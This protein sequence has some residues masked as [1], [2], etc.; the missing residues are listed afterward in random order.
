MK[1]PLKNKQPTAFTLIELLVVLAIIALLVAMIIPALKSAKENA[2]RVICASNL[3]QFG[4]IELNFAEDNN[5]EFIGR[6]KW[7]W[8]SYNMPDVSGGPWNNKFDVRPDLLEYGQTGRLFYCPS[9]TWHGPARIAMFE[10]LET[11]YGQL[12]IDYFLYVGSGW[13]VSWK[14]GR[15][16]YRIE[17][18][19]QVQAGGDQVMSSD[20]A[21][22]HVTMPANPNYAPYYTE[23]RPVRGN[24]TLAIG[25]DYPIQGGNRLY[26][27]GHVNWQHRDAIELA[28][29]QD[30]NRAM[31]FW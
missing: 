6:P 14:S 4:F 21:H 25:S 5:G 3:K 22:S 26:H 11:H 23:Q 19:S 2:R 12:E 8:P 28:A 18:Q 29:T 31:W 7:G 1:R 30:N 9:N 13:G 20:F 10:D 27:D 16:M 17:R 24:H 15:Q